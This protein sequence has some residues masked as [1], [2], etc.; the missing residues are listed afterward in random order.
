MNEEDNVD[1]GQDNVVEEAIDAVVVVECVRIGGVI[2]VKNLDYLVD[3]KQVVDCVVGTLA[4][5]P[6]LDGKLVVL[7]KMNG[8]KNIDHARETEIVD[9]IAW[10]VDADST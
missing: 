4:Y 9:R 2:D 8:V 1:E 5:S 10:E 6:E 3:R 7:K